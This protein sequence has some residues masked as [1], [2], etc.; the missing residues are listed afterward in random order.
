MTGR[1]LPAGTGS[2]DRAAARGRFGIDEDAD[3]VLV[4]GGSLGARRLNEAAL[5]AFGDGGS[6]RR[7]PRRGT[8]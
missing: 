2:A 1:P 6:L 3:C 4:F 8:A 5:E 7:A